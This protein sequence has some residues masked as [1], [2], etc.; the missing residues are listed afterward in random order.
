MNKNQ[1]ETETFS[2]VCKTDNIDFT[3]GLIN[4]NRKVSI[5]DK[6]KDIQEW[7]RHEDLE[8]IG[9]YIHPYK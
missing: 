9:K 6:Y 1:F 4:I 5:L 7:L 3:A 8:A 2:G